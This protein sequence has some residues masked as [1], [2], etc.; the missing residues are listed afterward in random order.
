MCELAKNV[1][2][3]RAAYGQFMDFITQDDQRLAKDT[4]ECNDVRIW[5]RPAA[6]NRLR[7]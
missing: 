4:S 3:A 5:R 1:E 7:H 2:Q 6:G